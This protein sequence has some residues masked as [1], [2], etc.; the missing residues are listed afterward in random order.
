MRECCIEM[1]RYKENQYL[2]STVD[3]MLF[4][5]EMI[6]LIERRNF[7][8]KYKFSNKNVNAWSNFQKKYCGMRINTLSHNFH[9]YIFHFDSDGRMAHVLG[10]KNARN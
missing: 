6:Y 4:M 8:Q 7:D 1:L 2:K 10:V 3:E 5:Q 9:S